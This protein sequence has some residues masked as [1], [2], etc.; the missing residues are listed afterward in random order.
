[1]SI[2]E[3]RYKE[4]LASKSNIVIEDQEDNILSVSAYT[5][6]PNAKKVIINENLKE[7][8]GH[9]FCHSHAL[10]AI[11][12]HPKNKKFK[13]DGK[14]LIA[15]RNKELMLCV[16]EPY[17]PDD[18]KIVNME[19]YTTSQER[20]ENFYIGK[21]LQKLVTADRFSI[22]KI[23]LSPEN[24]HFVLESDCLFIKG[25]NILVLGCEASIIPER[26]ENIG[27]YAF[28]M[29]KI[30]QLTIPTNITEIGLGA[31]SQ[32][33][34]TSV[35]IPSSVNY[36]ESIAFGYCRQLE[37]VT[38]GGGLSRI[39]K[40]VFQGCIS[41][42]EVNLPSSVTWV[43]SSLYN[44]SGV[45][46]ITSLGGIETI[47][48][49]M[50]ADCKNLRHVDLPNQIE[51]IENNAFDGCESLESVKFYCKLNECCGAIFSDCVSLR[52]VELPDKLEIIPY[53]T[54]FNCVS[55][56]EISLPKSVKKIDMHAFY[57]CR[58][59][60]RIN[61]KKVKVIDEKAFRRCLRLPSTKRC[62]RAVPYDLVFPISLAELKEKYSYGDKLIFKDKNEKDIAVT[63]TNIIQ[64]GNYG[65]EY[66]LVENGG[67]EYMIDI[68]ETL[69][70]E[71]Y[72]LCRSTNSGDS[73]W[74]I[75]RNNKYFHRIVMR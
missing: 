7:I 50:F 49:Y 63:Y 31:F 57:N 46:T 67:E 39:E 24:E 17:V 38:F 64:Y 52:K 6:Y 10:E 47:S 74:L 27:A 59:L 62:K 14:Y 25:T 40:S 68:N 36:I 32:T 29:C 30:K 37:Q 16:G 54:F 53:E 75:M 8:N 34:I 13:S 51:E 21:S 65:E 72:H 28:A 60:E 5:T 4:F 35:H 48:A 12:L 41:L 73:E 70:P 61:T 2:M 69:E 71:G 43:G 55:L 1:M 20:V 19:C 33:D 23:T 26:T 9:P 22:Q 58:M 11:E 3:D 18:V 42:R 44:G 56:E 15:K 45:D 66:A